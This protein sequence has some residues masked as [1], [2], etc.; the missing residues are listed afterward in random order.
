MAIDSN[1]DGD[2]QLVWTARLVPAGREGNTVYART[3]RPGEEDSGE[4]IHIEPGERLV[5][6]AGDLAIDSREIDTLSVKGHGGYAPVANTVWTWYRVV[7]EELNFFRFFT[8]MARRIDSAHTLWASA[9]QEI[10]KAKEE[11]AIPGR[12]ASFRALGT[13]E[14]AI[15]ALHRGIVMVQSL[16]DRYC[17]DLKVP[18]SVKKIHIAVHEM[19]LAFEHIDER[20][21]GR[22]G[23]SGKVDIGALTIFDQSDFLG[24]SVLRYKEHSLN[25]E[26]D[27]ISALL[28]CRELIMEAMDSRAKTHNDRMNRRQAT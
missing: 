14:M 15:I 21:E 8:S 25:F 23:M 4:T 16:V 11:G 3:L 6:Q 19:R 12:A 9:M 22:V 17:T 24:S 5:I 10:Q 2:G 1:N 18:D 20:A 13:S 26:T 28:D 27:V 7:G